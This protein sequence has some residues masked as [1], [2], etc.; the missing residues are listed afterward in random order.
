MSVESDLRAIL[1][2]GNIP[3]NQMAKYF[4]ACA[5]VILNAST[6]GSSQTNSELASDI[7]DLEADVSSLLSDIAA[8][9]SDITAVENLVANKEDAIGPKGSA[10]NKN[11]GTGAGE[12]AEGNHNH[13]ER[14]YTETEVNTLLAAKEASFTKNTAFNK[15]FGTGAGEVAEGNHNH[16]GTYLT[17]LGSI[18]GHTDVSISGQANRS[19]ISFNETTSQWEVSQPLAGID[20]IT[21]TYSTGDATLNTQL[22]NIKLAINEIIGRLQSFK[23]I[24]SGVGP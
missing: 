7:D 21:D 3:P 2:K 24:T 14:Y 19:L 11:F 20:E 10:F 1:G 4:I 18:G 16:D 12:V 23:V 9:E 8:I 5:K 6:G 13:D 22:D 17:S 15:N